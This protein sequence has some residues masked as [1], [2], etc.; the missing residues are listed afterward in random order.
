ERRWRA[1]GA[2]GTLPVPRSGP[3]WAFAAGSNGG[4]HETPEGSR[5]GGMTI[6]RGSERWR[7]WGGALRRGARR[8]AD[9]VPITPL[10]A[11]VA[12][13]AAL[14]L[15]EVGLAERDLVIVVAAGG[16]LAL[17]ALALVVVIAGAVRIKLA[18]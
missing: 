11:L 2:G 9:L 4:Q 17:V 7:R 12:V 16:A 14:S 18:S 1:V 3:K 10:G 6:E 13:V 5:A 8:V 15:R